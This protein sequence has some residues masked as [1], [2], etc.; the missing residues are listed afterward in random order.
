L[1]PEP[2]GTQFERL[3]ERSMRVHAPAK[4]NLNLLVGP[5]RSDGFHD[6][7]SIVC[8]VSLYDQIELRATSAKRISLTSR[9]F[10]CGPDEQNLAL[11]AAEMLARDRQTG[12]VEI[13]LAKH[14][15]PGRGLGGGSSDAA[16]VLAGLDRLWQLD[17]GRQE[18]L[19]LACRLGSDVPLFLGPP[20][21][22]MTGRGER[23]EPLG[24]HPLLAVLLWPEFGCHT[25]EVYRA[26][27]DEPA[28]MGRQLDARLLE[29]PPS[30]WRQKLVNQLQAGAGRVQPALADILENLRRSVSLPVC[31]T[32][33]GSAMFILCDDLQEAQAALAAIP[34]DLKL[35]RLIVRGNPW[36]I[37]RRV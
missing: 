6:L 33:S 35:Q 1:I 36:G 18:L 28:P 27:D 15:P 9:G 3:D 17:L 21:A 22:R 14:I 12:G 23:L 10:D 2:S 8:K 31:L 13:V 20:A 16:A 30:H 19:A 11:R 4:I 37:A 24:I 25:A 32:G 7:D 34:P 5:R 29:E 26:F